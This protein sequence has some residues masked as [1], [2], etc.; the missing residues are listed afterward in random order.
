MKLD[1]TPTTT[2]LDEIQRLQA[3]R[4]KHIDALNRIDDVL[5]KIA[6]TLAV[7]PIGQIPGDTARRV[8]TPPAPT[9]DATAAADA[10]RKYNKLPLTG[11]QF[12]LAF[13]REHGTATTLEINAAW[14]QQGRGGVANNAL[15]RLVKQGLLLREPLND[16]RGSRYRVSGRST[17]HAA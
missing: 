11:E 17:T 8:T 1:E 9:R 6:S 2:I 10:R 16:Q 14:R 3:D 12:I 5:K 13:V 4:Q 7:T 15:G